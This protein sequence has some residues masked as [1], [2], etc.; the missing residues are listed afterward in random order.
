MQMIINM[1]D[2]DMGIAEATAAPRIHHQWLP[3]IVYYEKGISADTLNVM[4]DLGHVINDEPNIMGATQ[5]I[6]RERGRLSGVSDPRRH[7]SAAIPES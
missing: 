3:D 6:S 2:Y 1:I 5:C 7:G 4:K